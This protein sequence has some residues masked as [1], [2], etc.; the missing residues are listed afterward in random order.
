M[1]Q[2]ETVV[3]LRFAADCCPWVEKLRPVLPLPVGLRDSLVQLVLS[4]LTLSHTG[5]RAGAA[6]GGGEAVR[7][8]GVRVHP[9]RRRPRHRRAAAGLGRR[10]AA[11][12]PGLQRCKTTES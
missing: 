6:A 10:R 12:A 2:R 11:G 5:S 7:P 1:S 4:P 8:V 9:R 3:E